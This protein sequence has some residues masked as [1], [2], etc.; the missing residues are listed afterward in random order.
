M[1][2]VWNLWIQNPSAPFQYG[3]MIDAFYVAIAVGLICAL[4]SCFMILK[5]WSLMGDAISHAIFP[6]VVIGYI[7]GIPLAVGA[8]ISGLVCALSTGYIKARSRIKEDTVMGVVFTGM[9]ALGL[10]IFTKIES[11]IHL[12]HILFGN[13]LGMTKPQVLQTILT[14]IVMTILVAIIRKDLFLYCFDS[15]HART[16]GIQASRLYYLFLCLISLAVVISLQAVGVILVISM[17]ITPGCTARLLTKHFDLMLIIAA[18]SAMSSAFLGTYISYFING[19]T[20]AC[21]VL[22]QSLQFIMAFTLHLRAR[23]RA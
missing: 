10:V 9:F 4:L 12:N 11:D 14:S 20:G 3:F 21:I 18:L 6:G 1:K 22:V 13:L 19:A 16:I 8:F 17:L 2:Q 23:V 15:N 5:G 7:I